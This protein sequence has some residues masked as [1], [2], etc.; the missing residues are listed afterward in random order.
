VWDESATSNAGV[1]SIPSQHR[2][3]QQ[4]LIHWQP[5]RDL[6]LMFVGSRHSEQLSLHSQHRIVSNVEDSVLRTE[7]SGLESQEEDAPKRILY[8]FL[9]RCI[10][11]C[12]K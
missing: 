7:M 4:I 6:K 11:D 3:A 9:N 12:N 5:F 1:T 10:F 8:R 2:V